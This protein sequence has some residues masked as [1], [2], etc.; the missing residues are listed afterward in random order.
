MCAHDST[1]KNAHARPCDTLS[2]GRAVCVYV[3]VCVC[4]RGDGEFANS[5]CRVRN[6]QIQTPYGVCA[7]YPRDADDD[8]FDDGGAGAG[9]GRSSATNLAVARA[10]ARSE[11]HNINLARVFRERARARGKPYHNARVHGVLQT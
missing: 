10:R 8:G 4:V 7:P 2:H 6:V 5:P 11:K 3:L 1:H 9:A